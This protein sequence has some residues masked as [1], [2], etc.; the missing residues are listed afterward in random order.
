[1]RA[2]RSVRGGIS[3]RARSLVSGSPGGC[4]SDVVPVNGPVSRRFAQSWSDGSYL[5][6]IRAFEVFAPHRLRSPYEHPRQGGGSRLFIATFTRRK[7]WWQVVSFPGCTGST[8]CRVEGVGPPWCRYSNQVRRVD[9][10]P[11]Q[12]T[13]GGR[14][15]ARSA[16]RREE[17]WPSCS[18][19]SGVLEW[20]LPASRVKVAR[21]LPVCYI[22][23][24]CS[25]IFCA[26]G[27]GI[28]PS[29][30]IPPALRYLLRCLARYATACGLPCP[31]PPLH[32]FGRSMMRVVPTELH[33]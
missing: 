23:E 19:G 28:V 21:M 18:M 30:G 22:G 32:P 4:E 33:A 12:L 27:R 3:A 16:V 15:S 5:F 31:K 26:I 13:A 6:G 2:G 25:A 1:V 17:H 24:R 10:P 11:D 9:G 14:G 20:Q 8:A 7:A 29:R